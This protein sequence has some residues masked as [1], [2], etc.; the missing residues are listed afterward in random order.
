M[1]KMR[2]KQQCLPPICGNCL[3]MFMQPIYGE[4]G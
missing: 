1:Q 2:V 4:L 3:Y